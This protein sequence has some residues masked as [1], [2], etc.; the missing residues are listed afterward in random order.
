MGLLASTVCAEFRAQQA[1]LYMGT[2]AD[3]VA[4]KHGG[5]LC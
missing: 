2:A 5:K 3:P 4:T 1:P